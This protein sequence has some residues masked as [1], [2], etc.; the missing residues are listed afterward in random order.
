VS[1]TPIEKFRMKLQAPL[2]LMLALAAPLSALSTAHAA[3]LADIYRLASEQDSV[4]Q[5][6]QAQYEASVRL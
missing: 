5:A 3:N 4:I 2:A 6:T 1:N